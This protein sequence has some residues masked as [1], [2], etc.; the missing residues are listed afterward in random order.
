MQAFKTL[1]AIA[2]PL[3]RDNIDTDAI[4][5]SREIKR[6]GKVGLADGL[7]AGW[8][9]LAGGR[10]PNPDFVL[11][12]AAYAGARILIG[13]SNFGCGSSREHAVWALAEY[14]FRA[15]LA[16]SFAPIFFDNC[17]NNG[18]LAARLRAESLRLIA[19]LNTTQPNQSAR[20][21]NSP[22][23]LTLDLE[24]CEV[25]GAGFGALAFSIE[26]HARARLLDGLDAID[27]TLR[28]SAAIDDFRAAD[29]TR[30]PWA[31][32]EDPA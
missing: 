8:R 23:L 20:P 7:F 17:L 21:T 18:L 1:T 22:T 28:S 32:L 25:T 13:G 14:G 11:N 16:P 12:D 19:S 2:A 10:E 3:V 26:P 31:Y 6:V 9:Y 27:F 30:R 29:R 24:R 15:I 4:I 5:P